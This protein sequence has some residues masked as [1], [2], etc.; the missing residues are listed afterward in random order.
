MKISSNSIGNT[1][2]LDSSRPAQRSD[3]ASRAF[4]LKPKAEPAS[5]AGVKPEIK[6]Q[7]AE[8]PLSVA[9]RS[10]AADF[11]AGRISTKEE[12]IQ[13]TVSTMLHEQFSGKLAQGKGYAKMEKSISSLIVDDPA[14]SKRIET[15]LNRL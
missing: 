6:T 8:A 5:S 3:R 12:A 11:K 7:P 15:L 10:V 2:R 14:L 13:K 4:A 9:L 1:P